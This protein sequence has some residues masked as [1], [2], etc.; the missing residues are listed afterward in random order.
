MGE[1]R[2]W[3]HCVLRTCVVVFWVPECPLLLVSQLLK[4][5]YMSCLKISIV[6]CESILY[7]SLAIIKFPICNSCRNR[8]FVCKVSKILDSVLLRFLFFTFFVILYSA[9]QESMW[10]DVNWWTKFF[11]LVFLI[12][13]SISYNSPNSPSFIITQ[14]GRLEMFLGEHNP[15]A[16]FSGNLEIVMNELRRFK[17]SADFFA[18]SSHIIE[19][20]AISAS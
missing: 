15:E 2:V 6:G 20:A 9:M 18:N 11:N 5:T 13:F 8:M 7:S 4:D 17:H 3:L 1:K 14:A 19:S 16:I 12:F 10:I